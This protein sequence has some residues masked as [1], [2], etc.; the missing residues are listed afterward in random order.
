TAR[1]RSS[2]SNPSAARTTSN[3]S[4]SKFTSR[5]FRI[6]GSSSTTSTVAGAIPEWYTGVFERPRRPRRRIAASRAL[7]AQGLEQR[8]PEPCAQVRILPRALTSALIRAYIGVGPATVAAPQSVKSPSADG[9]RG[10][11]EPVQS[12]GDLV[13]TVREEPGIDVQ[14]G[15]HIAVPE[16]PL[17]GHGVSAASNQEA[18]TR[19]PEAVRREP[20]GQSRVDYR[21]APDRPPEALVAQRRSPLAPEH[22]LVGVGPDDFELPGQPLDQEVG[23][24]HPPALERLRRPVVKPPVDVGRRLRHL[25]PAPEKNAPAAPEGCHL[26]PSEPTVSQEVD[27]RAVRPGRFGQAINLRRGQEDGFSPGGPGQPD[28]GT[29]V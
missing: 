12:R 14:R 6:T 4:I 18:G 24:P 1:A 17:N 16:V 8:P 9:L 2:P 25:D 23:E 10:P 3:P 28:P 13:E 22:E 15:R 27:E 7:V 11:V 26:T 21:P 20:L 19:V 29:W 5:S